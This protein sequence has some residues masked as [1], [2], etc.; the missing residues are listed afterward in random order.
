[1]VQ[2]RFNRRGQT[3]PVTIN[4]QDLIYTNGMIQAENEMVARVN[5]LTFRRTTNT[6]KM[7]VSLASLK[8]KDAGDGAWQIFSAVSR[9]QR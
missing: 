1:M 9:E 8:R 5:A 2:L 4:L 7:E 6:P 3:S